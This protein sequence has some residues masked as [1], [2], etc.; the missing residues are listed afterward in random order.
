[1]R[2]C[3]EALDS[4]GVHWTMPRWNNLSVARRADVA[5]LDELIGPKC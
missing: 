1:M 3:Q 2:W 4:I 5:L